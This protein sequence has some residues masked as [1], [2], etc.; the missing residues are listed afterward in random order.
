MIKTTKSNQFFLF[1]MY[2]QFLKLPLFLKYAALKS[3]VKSKKLFDF[4]AIYENIHLLNNNKFRIDYFRSAGIY[5]YK[6]KEKTSY[7]VIENVSELIVDRFIE[8]NTIHKIDF[9]FF[10]V[11]GSFKHVKTIYH[12]FTDILKDNLTL[13][14]DDLRKYSKAKRLFYKQI[15]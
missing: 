5:G 9:F 8:Y 10:Y 13:F 1:G 11:K 4:N 6:K 7:Q 3:F 15:K 2:Y 12:Y 14:S